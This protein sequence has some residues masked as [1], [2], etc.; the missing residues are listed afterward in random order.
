MGCCRSDSPSSSNGWQEQHRSQ[1][2]LSSSNSA[3]DTDDRSRTLIGENSTS[4]S[5]PS[6][7]RERSTE[8]SFA[9]FFP[10]RYVTFS[11]TVAQWQ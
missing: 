9:S 7:I 5:S 2:Q 4:S 6:M 3:G 8:E 1:R 11:W 10:S